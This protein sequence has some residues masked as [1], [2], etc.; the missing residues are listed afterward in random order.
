MGEAYIVGAAR[1]PLGKRKGELAGMHPVDLLG[2][3]QSGL[4]S[5]LGLKAD[6]DERAAFVHEHLRGAGADARARA[7]DVLVTTYEYVMRDK[8]TLRRTEWQYIIVDEGHRMKNANSKFAQTLGTNYTSKRRVLLTGTP[9]QNSL[10]ELWALLNF[11]LPDVFSS[12]D[13]FDDWFSLDSG[14][15]AKDNVVKKLHTVLKPFMLRRVKKD[16]AK[17]LPPKREVKLYTG[18]T[19][20]QKKGWAVL[21]KMSNG[22][23][24]VD[25]TWSGAVHGVHIPMDRESGRPRGFAFV[26]FGSAQDAERA[27]RL[28]R[29][30]RAGAVHINGGAYEYGSPFGGY[31]ASGNG[32]EGGAMGLEDFLETKMVHNMP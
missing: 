19:E 20:L 12:S 14:E 28:S 7:W 1:S 13:T 5:R 18:L 25:A 16:V 30:L 27:A 11:L 31:K 15:G 8:S 32:R 2:S 17:D 23:I 21:E 29:A 26:R 24:T 22:K 3:V 4:I 10:P 6:E 9:L